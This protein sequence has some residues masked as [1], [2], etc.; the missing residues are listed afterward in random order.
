MCVRVSMLGGVR[1]REIESE[2]ERVC[3]GLRERARESV[4]QREREREIEIH[5]K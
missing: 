3:A 2:I 4:C 1:G 5:T